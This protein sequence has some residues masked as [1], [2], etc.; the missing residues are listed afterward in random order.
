MDELRGSYTIRTLPSWAL[1]LI[2]LLGTAVGFAIFILGA[3]LLLFLVPLLIV[4]GLI[5][6]WRFRHLARKAYEEGRAD[7]PPVIDGE[8]KVVDE[9]RGKFR[10]F[11]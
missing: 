11:R 4:A 8:F 2:G 6:R 10:I 3:G 7:G 9:R 1:A 5:A